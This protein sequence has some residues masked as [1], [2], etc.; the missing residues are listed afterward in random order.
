MGLLKN[1]GIWSFGL[2][3]FGIAMGYIAE[4][5]LL[6]PR[7]LGQVWIWLCFV[8]EIPGCLI[9]KAYFAHPVIAVIILFGVWLAVNSESE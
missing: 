5:G 3:I 9:S 8:L 2:V 1:I 7:L 4:L 6:M